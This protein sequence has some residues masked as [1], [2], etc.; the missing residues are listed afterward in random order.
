MTEVL[1]VIKCPNCKAV[2]TLIDSKKGIYQCANSDDACY[3]LR[4]TD[5]GNHQVHILPTDLHIFYK[6]SQQKAS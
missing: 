3:G 1:G 5:L 2:S 6:A 4:F